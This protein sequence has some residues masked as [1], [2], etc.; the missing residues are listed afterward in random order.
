MTTLL[1]IRH[2]LTE[3]A[4][5]VLTGWARGVHL[6]PTGRRQAD[7]LVGRLDGVPVDAIYT[8][9]LER[10]RETAAPLARAR[11]LQVRVRRE[12]IETSYGEWTGRSIA[13]L[14]RSKDWRIVML[15]P[16]AVRF[17]GGESLREVQGRTLDAI[18][19]IAAEHPDGTVAVVSHADPIRMLLLHAG[20]A[21]LD[22]LHR[23]HVDPASVSVVRV[24]SE[25]TI[26][27]V[28]V[29]DTSDLSAL[30]PAPKPR[31]RKVGG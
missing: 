8:S 3:T 18:E 10:C 21:H 29:N 2:G 5:K 7:G 11:G 30:R 31:S 25:R 12:L 14:R 16:S 4:G 13:R 9:P 23:W 20:G 17:P 6:N 1:L 26:H 24:T 22:A 28:K 15:A 19:A 27:L